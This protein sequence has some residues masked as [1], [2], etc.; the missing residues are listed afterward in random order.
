MKGMAETFKTPL[1]G[2][3]G[4]GGKI[5]QVQGDLAKMQGEMVSWRANMTAEMSNV[6]SVVA[7]VQKDVGL[8]S[9]GIAELLAREN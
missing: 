4:A 1:P 7:G 5:A 6:M 9:S 2:A 3:D 8:V